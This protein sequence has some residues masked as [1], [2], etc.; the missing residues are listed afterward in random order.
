MCSTHKSWYKAA[1]MRALKTVCQT[2]I[3]TIGTSVYMG[4]VNW[5]AVGSASI[6]AGVLSVLTSLAGLPE[7]E[8]KTEEA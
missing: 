4:E 2:A 8:E 1:A 6:L 3:A 7:C 5:M